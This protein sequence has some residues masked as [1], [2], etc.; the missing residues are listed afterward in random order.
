METTQPSNT[1]E[2]HGPQ[3][4][5]PAQPSP[6]PTPTVTQ[7][8]EPRSLG[9]SEAM[10]RRLEQHYLPP[11]VTCDQLAAE[12]ARV[13]AGHKGRH[14]WAGHS[15]GRDPRRACGGWRPMA[16]VTCPV[17]PDVCPECGAYWV[18]PFPV[19]PRDG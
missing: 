17:C 10:K 18:S 6:E 7:A 13:R 1:S 2:P 12:A 3:D 19:D 9:L 15:S 8:R 5:T 4:D 14:H 11:G 16:G